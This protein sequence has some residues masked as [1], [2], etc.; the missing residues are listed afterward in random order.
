[1]VIKLFF[2]L[3]TFH[4]KIFKSKTPISLAIYVIRK[5]PRDLN[6]ESKPLVSLHTADPNEQEKCGR[7]FFKLLET[8]IQRV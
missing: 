4:T 3:L 2:L 8:Y 7:Q 5:V 6:E 1:M